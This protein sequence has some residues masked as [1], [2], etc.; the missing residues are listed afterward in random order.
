MSLITSDVSDEEV[1]STNQAAE[2]TL[3]T[4]VELCELVREQERDS[5]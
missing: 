4:K 2:G 3:I 5:F 1:G